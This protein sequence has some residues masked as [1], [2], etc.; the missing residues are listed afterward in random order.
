MLAMCWHLLFLCD[1][2]LSVPRPNV[3]VFTDSYLLTAYINLTM[4][5]ANIGFFF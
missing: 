1:I 4:L 5:Y 3:A 2:I